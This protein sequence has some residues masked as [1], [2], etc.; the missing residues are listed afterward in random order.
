[1]LNSRDITDLREDV[2]YN[3]RKLIEAA[4]SEGL[5]VLITGTLRD[6]EYQK[7]C[8]MNGAAKTA[9]L[10]PHGYGLAFDICKNIKGHEYD[11]LVFFTRVANIAKEMGFT[12]GGDWKS[13]PDR[14]HF[15]WM[16]NPPISQE[17]LRNGERP[18]IMP[19]YG[20]GDIMRDIPPWAKEAVQWAIDE[21]I[22]DG[23]GLTDPTPFYRLLMVLY[24]Y[25]NRK[26]EK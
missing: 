13:F 4:K 12:W 7:F 23:T 2:Q 21:G 16:G 8:F 24:K 25:N 9:Q 19:K 5:P 6:E 22:A 15:E 20:E 11:D 17:R 14:P 1:M 26:D 10:G 3:C 18:S